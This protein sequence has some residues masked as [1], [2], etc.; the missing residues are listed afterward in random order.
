[1]FLSEAAAADAIERA[2]IP[3]KVSSLITFSAAGASDP[4]CIQRWERSASIRVVSPGF[5]VEADFHYLIR[6][7]RAC[8][9]IPLLYGQDFLNRYEELLDDF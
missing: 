6:D 8:I 5:A 1:M 2:G 9:A 4:K 7:L 3:Y